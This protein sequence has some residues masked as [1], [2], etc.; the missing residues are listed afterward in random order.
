ML[1]RNKLMAGLFGLVLAA[2]AGTAAAADEQFV[3]LTVY[4]VGAVCRRR[5]GLLRRLSSTT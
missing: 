1:H 4:R 3:P 5:L 2:V